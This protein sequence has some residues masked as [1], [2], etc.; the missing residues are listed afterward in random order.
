MYKEEGPKLI[1][2]FAGVTPTTK[3]AEI[4]PAIIETLN[5]LITKRLTSYSF[6]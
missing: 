6:C 3:L 4:N 2:A 1:A 5:F